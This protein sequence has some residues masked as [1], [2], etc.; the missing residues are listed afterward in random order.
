MSVLEIAQ[1][2]AHNFT[3]QVYILLKEDNFTWKKLLQ[4]KKKERNSWN[5]HLQIGVLKNL[6][7]N[8]H[9]YGKI[10]LRV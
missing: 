7:E 5:K 1:D 10:F 6:Q 2:I 4:K 3:V 8:F 9:E